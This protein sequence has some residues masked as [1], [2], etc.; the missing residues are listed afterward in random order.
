MSILL[1]FFTVDLS[2]S[3]IATT[4]QNLFLYKQ[5]CSVSSDLRNRKTGHKFSHV[6]KQYLVSLNTSDEILGVYAANDYLFVLTKQLISV[7]YMK[8][9]K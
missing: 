3:V 5:R 1:L 9:V 7:Y 2:Y 8:D 6:G 4:K